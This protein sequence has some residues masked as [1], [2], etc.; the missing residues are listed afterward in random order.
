M[1]FPCLY[2]IRQKFNTE[3]ITEIESEII[4]QF[5]QIQAKELLKPGMRIA[6][7]A[8]SRGIANIPRII[9]T[10]CDFLKAHQ[11]QPFIVPA[12]GSHGGATAE[13]QVKVL[14]KL[15]ITEE[16]MGVPIVSDMTVVEIGHTPHSVPVYMDKN[17]YNAD[18]IVVVN[19]VKPHTDFFDEIESGLMKMIAVGL[20]KEKGATT[21]HARGLATNILES[22]RVSLANAPILFGL[23]IVENAKDET[24]KL[25]ALLPKDFEAE[26]KK[27]LQEAKQIVPHIPADSLDVLV[28]QEM[29]KMY[30]G[31]GMDTKVLGR[32]RVFGET[33]PSSPVINKVVVLDL[34]DNSYGNALG[35]G[36]ADIT[37]KRLVDKID[38]QATYANLIPTTYLERGKIPVVMANDREAIDLAMRTAGDVTPETVKIAV[39][40][41]TLHLEEL[42]V[43]APLLQAIKDPVEVLGPWE[44][45]F[46]EDGSLQLPWG[47]H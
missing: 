23:A 20:G 46:T 38:F 39:I 33:E 24:Y 41:N 35:V 5:E 13:G 42:L 32:I 25:K 27:L 44:M 45:S 47:R 9:R 4:R 22:A 29:G 7:T 1:E 12:M 10:V 43:S 3:K 16:T 6:V 26:E 30:S 18:G 31:T 17:A 19:R 11:T 15:G 36:L 8:G 21:M 2:H 34:A 37:T 40:H 14:S 28:V